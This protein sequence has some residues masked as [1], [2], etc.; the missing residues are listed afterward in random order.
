M[1]SLINGLNEQQKEVVI[2]TDGPILVLAGAG[3]GKTKAL[4]HR[5]SFLLEQGLAH[6]SEILAVTFTNKAAKEME[7]RVYK[8][9]EAIGYPNQEPILLVTFHSFGA[10]VLREHA[11]RLGYDSYFTIYDES[12]QL[13]MVKKVLK[14]INISESQLEPKQAQRWI[15]NKKADDSRNQKK[16]INAAPRFQILE[17]VFQHYEKS[18]LKANAMDFSDLLY[19]TYL[20]FKNHP[21]VLSFYSSRFKYIMV[22]EYQDT[23][24]LQY[25][26]IKMLSQGHGNLC[27]VGDED[28]SIYSWRG[29]DISNI[30]DFEVDYPQSKVIRLEQNY[31]STQK[32]VL[33]A[34]AV[35]R[36]NVSRK[37]KELFT[38][39]DPGRPIHFQLESNDFDEARW[40]TR[41]IQKIKNN[42][43]ISWSQFCILYRTNAQSRLFEEQLRLMGVPYRIVGGLRFYDRAEI[44]DILSYLRIIC[45]PKDDVAFRR[46][47]NV[48][49]R[50]IGKTT[51]EK[52]VDVGV[53]RGLSLW[54]VSRFVVQEKMLPSGTLTKLKNFL[55]LLE[56]LSSSLSEKSLLE[57][58]VY[59]LEETGY[60]KSLKTENTEESKSRVQN[61][62]EFSNAIEQYEKES[63]EASLSGFLEEMAL[64]S[65]LDQVD[66]NHE[67]VTMMTVHM[68]KGLEFPYV[69]VVGLEENLFPSSRG[70]EN[71]ENLEEERRLFYV[72]MTRAEKELFLSAAKQ[73][74]FWGQEQFNPVARFVSEIPSEYIEMGQGLVAKAS[75]FLSKR[76]SN[77]WDSSFESQTYFDEN[78]DDKLEFGF[79]EAGWKEGLRV[80]HPHFGKGIIKGVEGLGDETRLTVLFEGQ[81]V[82]KFI[83]KFA[84]LETL[85]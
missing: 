2:T 54:E 80:K 81:S 71:P 72:A 63:L 1:D 5:L 9:L 39:N 34:S 67:A 61:L 3:S 53:S 29:A 49:T 78:Q 35:I 4:T 83:A 50:G 16:F 22:D 20:L 43:Q 11:K 55:E 38:S 82:K 74:R 37:G 52:L 51:V 17:E 33:A 23:N 15:N 47:I 40:V 79:H 26:L 46:I 56:K 25:Q 77:E 30:L 59:L 31:R 27:V 10:K 28:Q 32:I 18:M 21:D 36:N 60:L 7:S 44:K 8:L 70:E 65:D 84:K 48:P 62:E 64:V 75:S 85:G 19:K 6:P 66:L 13:Q 41:Q 73:R 69:F 58:Y 14:E 24:F 57:F 45:N 12:D 68:A 76:Q 42:N